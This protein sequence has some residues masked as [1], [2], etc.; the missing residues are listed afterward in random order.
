MVEALG[1]DAIQ[2][3]ERSV[4]QVNYRYQRD[5]TENEAKG[6]KEMLRLVKGRCENKAGKKG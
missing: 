4:V 6:K 5:V 3:K 1:G 2:G